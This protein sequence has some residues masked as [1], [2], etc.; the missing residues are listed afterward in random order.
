MAMQTICLGVIFI[1]TPL[2]LRAMGAQ[3]Y[4]LVSLS[5]GIAS[6][7]TLFDIGGGWAVM[8]YVPLLRAKSQGAT[9]DEAFTVALL[10]SLGAGIVGAA[11]IWVLAPSLVGAL[12]PTA[13][14][15]VLAMRTIQISGLW[16]PAVLAVGVLNGAGRAIGRVRTAATL[17]AA[18][19]VLFNLLWLLIA[20][21]NKSPEDVALAQLFV[22]VALLL[23]WTA[24][25]ITEPASP[26]LRRP[27][28]L[29]LAYEIVRF[30]ALSS[31]AQMGA[32]MLIT[33]GTLAVSS[34]VGAAA[35]VYYSIPLSIVQ[36]LGIVSSTITTIVFPHFSGARPDETESKSH[37]LSYSNVVVIGATGGLASILLWAGSPGLSLWISHNFAQRASFPLKILTLGFLLICMSSVY[38]V[39]LEAVGRNVVITALNVLGGIV[40]LALCLVLSRVD[41][42]SGGALGVAAGLCL[43]GVT[44]IG[45]S[46]LYESV[47]TKA[48]ILWTLRT[49]SL[50]FG[51]GATVHF[52]IRWSVRTTPVTDAVSVATI[53]CVVGLTASVLVYRYARR[54]QR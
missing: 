52:I 9:A 30:S 25:L 28:S 22:S 23:L 16:L 35:V 3:R 46:M 50:I 38:Q 4:A 41:G 6:Y 18:S 8:R 2:Q 7:G 37:L 14:D 27:R 33:A 20:T 43:T 36:R 32:T 29:R 47:P 11:V 26:R 45:A 17:S 39:H 48:E 34:S 13:G 1:L 21:H 12:R 51:T 40:G 44:I 31:V 53:V 54:L 5:A 49:L 42:A 19:V 15:R 24:I 10:A